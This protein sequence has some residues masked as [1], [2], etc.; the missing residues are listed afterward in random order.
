MSD[1]FERFMSGVDTI[2]PETETLAALQSQSL[3]IKFGADPSA[4]DLHLGHAVILTK[5]RLLQDMGHTVIFLIG[6]FTAMIGDPTGKSQTRKP[7]TKEQVVENAESYKAQVFKFLDPDKTEVVYNSEWLSKLS[8]VDVVKLS[9]SYTVAR[10][11][12][13]DDFSK[14]YASGTPISVHE[15]LYPLFQGY[16][17]VALK[18]DV[19]VG[20]TDQTFNL[21]MG[22]HLQ[23]QENMS[24]Q[25]IVTFPILEGLDGVQ[26][27]SKSLGNHIAVLDEPNNMFGKV[28]SIPD[29]LITRYFQLLS[30]VS[31]SELAQ[32]ES[33]LASG[34]NPRDVKRDLGK[35]IVAKLHSDDAAEQAIQHFDTVFA[36]RD[37]PDDIPVLNVAADAIFLADFLLEHGLAPSKK[38]AR[39]LIAQGAV[40]INQEKS[41]LMSARCITRL[42]MMC[43]KLVNDGLLKYRLC[44]G[45]AIFG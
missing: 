26:K 13:R 18:S 34:V 39:R 33:D 42:M 23:Q 32:I 20:G 21:L 24:A 27:M 41:L 19:E 43:L 7:L 6:D 3:R 28:M 4:P 5:L 37:I 30:L 38:E 9:S 29:T 15:F 10:M 17:S 11:L 31:P 1:L 14:R 22:R 12:E 40:S 25:S 8:A 44:S 16:D 2:I 45:L 35:R 36:K